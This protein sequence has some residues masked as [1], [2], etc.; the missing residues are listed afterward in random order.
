MHH[1]VVYAAAHGL[2]DAGCETLRIA[3]RGVGE[4]TGDYDE[5]R[6]EL[7]DARTALEFLFAQRAERPAVVVAAG[8]SFGAMIALR[9]AR[10][11]RRIT[12]V[13]AI[14]TPAERLA[15]EDLVSDGRPRLFVHGD[16]DELAPLAGLRERLGA[17]VATDEIRVLAADHFFVGLGDQIRGNIREWLDRQG[18]AI[19]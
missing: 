19:C 11:D 6:G 12:H 4:S 16:A 13:V 9:L 18:P 2:G 10:Q 7:E 8:Y 1:P 3:F 15:P 14:A 5:G 17:P